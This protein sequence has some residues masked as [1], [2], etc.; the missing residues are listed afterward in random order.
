MTPPQEQPI[1][2]EETRAMTEVSQEAREAAGDWLTGEGCTASLPEILS[3]SLAFARYGQSI[4]AQVVAEYVER[5]R[6]MCGDTVAETVKE[7][8]TD[9]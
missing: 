1:P 7:D 3:L 9:G 6:L 2:V 5:V 4:R 8:L